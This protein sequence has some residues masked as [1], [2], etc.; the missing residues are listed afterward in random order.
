MIPHCT[1]RSI[2]AV[3]R[4]SFRDQDGT[5]P[6]AESN[7]LFLCLIAGLQ[8]DGVQSS[9]SSRTFTPWPE[10]QRSNAR[11]PLLT[12]AAERWR[13]QLGEGGV[14]KCVHGH[15]GRG[16]D[17]FATDLCWSSQPLRTTQ[18]VTTI[19]GYGCIIAL[20]Q[21]LSDMFLERIKLRNAVME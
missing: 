13:R 14:F 10:S 21:I 4:I 1:C 2:T 11:E 20:K 19:Y 8:S 3:R 16:T 9:G 18:P 17:T 6:S 15:G 12:A 7:E 5:T